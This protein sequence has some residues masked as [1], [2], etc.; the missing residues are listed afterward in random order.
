MAGRNDGILIGNPLDPRNPRLTT[1]LTTD[2]KPVLLD[3]MKTK[4]ILAGCVALLSF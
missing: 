2:W 1:T 3:S 4:Y